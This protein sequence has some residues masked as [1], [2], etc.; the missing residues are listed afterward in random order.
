MQLG[1]FKP[2]IR[3]FLNEKALGMPNNSGKYLKY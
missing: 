3:G 2:Y 1:D